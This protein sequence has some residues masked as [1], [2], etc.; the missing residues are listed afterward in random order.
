MPRRQLIFFHLALARIVSAATDKARTHIPHSRVWR[1]HWKDGTHLFDG[2]KALGG[3]GPRPSL[4]V[5]NGRRAETRF[6]SGLDRGALRNHAE[7]QELP[8]GDH[9]FARHG[10]D[11][12]L[13][14][15]PFTEFSQCEFIMRNGFSSKG[16]CYR[17]LGRVR[18]LI[19]RIGQSDP[20]PYLFRGGRPRRPRL[21]SRPLPRIDSYQA[22]SLI[23]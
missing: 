18:L 7:R 6:Q 17:S 5:A 21:A 11:H 13:G 8:Q 19:T 10:H 20:W 23:L 1:G 15:A 9:Q 16:H 12:G 2:V 14:H 22:A 4:S 3:S